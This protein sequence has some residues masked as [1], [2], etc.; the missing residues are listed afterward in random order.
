MDIQTR[1]LIADDHEI[2]RVG[3]VKT[4]ERDKNFSIIAQA[5]DGKEALTLIREMRPDIAVLDVSMPVMN[6][7]DVGRSVY[8]EALPTELIF[9]TMYK[10][11][12]YFNAAMD[13]GA[14]GYL[15][16]DN[17]SA[18]LLTCLRAVTEGKHYISQTISH[19]LVDRQKN[20]EALAQSVPTLQHL[21]P[22]ERHILTLLVDNLTSKEIA[23]KLF[24]S[25]RTVENHRTHMCQKLGIK[26][27]NRLLQFAIENKSGL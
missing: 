27:H 4:I 13:I 19:F 8:H 25:V 26:G 10:D 7:L 5:G 12:A 14:R 21:S 2:F 22:A 1:V 24:V 9:L 17:A 6:G 20:A 18:D 3:L 16:K 15:L 23:D 11:L